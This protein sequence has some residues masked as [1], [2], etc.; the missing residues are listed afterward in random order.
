MITYIISIQYKYLKYQ[1]MLMSLMVILQ[2]SPV[3]R[4]IALLE[5]VIKVPIARMIQFTGV[6]IA[7][8]SAPHA[9]AGATAFTS[10]P[11]SPTTGNTGEAFNMVFAMTGT[12]SAVKSWTILG[13]LPP[14]SAYPASTAQHSMLEWERL[15]GPRLLPAFLT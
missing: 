3:M 14:A 7:T 5:K 13:D 8:T 2:K 9:F 6:A 15:Q 4:T 11:S 10:N 12:P 1:L